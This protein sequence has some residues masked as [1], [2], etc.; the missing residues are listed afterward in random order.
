[1]SAQAPAPNLAA[2]APTPRVF[3]D[4]YCSVTCHNQKLK[5]AGLMLDKVDLAKPDSSAASRLVSFVVFLWAI[6]DPS[7]KLRMT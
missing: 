2:A 3:L 6:I 5:T 7:P 1:M 4:T